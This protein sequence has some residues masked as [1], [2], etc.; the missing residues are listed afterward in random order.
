ML[1]VFYNPTRWN[2]LPIVLHPMIVSGRRDIQ[3]ISDFK[4]LSRSH[5]E[6]LL[7]V[8][9]LRDPAA[10]EYLREQY[11]DLRKRYSV[12]GYFDDGD[13]AE[14]GQRQAEFIDYFDLWFKKQLHKDRSLYQYA[15]P[16]TWDSAVS[17]SQTPVFNDESIRKLR[18]GWNLLA[19][20]YSLNPRQMKLISMIDPRLG[21]TPA[22]LAF[23]GLKAM[24][25][26]YPSRDVQPADRSFNC[27]ARFTADGYPEGIA[28]QRKRFLGLINEDPFFLTG[29][30]DTKKYAQEMM[31]VRSV[32]SP[33]GYGEIC[34]RD[35]EAIL[36][37]ALLIKPDMSHLETW[38]DCFIDRETYAAIEWDGGHLVEQAKELTSDLDFVNRVTKSA[39][40]A[41]KDSYAEMAARVDRLVNEFN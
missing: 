23:L 35:A 31:Q 10:R 33:F 28:A 13:S 30:V 27:H 3:F 6:H 21:H 15:R 24:A 7:I 37:G 38:P 20:C 29:R 36:S 2:S 18:L 16:R 39:L 34:Y 5:G 32:L 40:C 19:G 11:P 26:L 41:L 8:A 1:T 25:S 22:R 4:R 14:V 9:W 12:I 17:A